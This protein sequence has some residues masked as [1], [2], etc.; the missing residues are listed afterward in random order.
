MTPVE[1]LHHYMMAQFIVQ[2][3]RWRKASRGR[4][5]VVMV[6][7]CKAD[8]RAV[9]ECIAELRPRWASVSLLDPLHREVAGFRRK[10]DTVEAWSAA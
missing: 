7:P 3:E 2:T 6:P 5:A 1:T 10:G 4:D 8:W 9:A